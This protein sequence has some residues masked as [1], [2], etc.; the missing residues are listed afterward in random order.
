M[1][2]SQNRRHSSVVVAFVAQVSVVVAVQGAFVV[3]VADVVVVDFKV[4]VDVGSVVARVVD[5]CETDV[6]VVKGVVVVIEDAV[7]LLF[8]P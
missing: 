5:G 6:C 4:V 3:V 2:V 8:E 1:T 7:L